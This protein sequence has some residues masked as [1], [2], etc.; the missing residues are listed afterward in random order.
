MQFYCAEINPNSTHSWPGISCMKVMLAGCDFRCGYCNTPE[1]VD[2]KEEYLKLTKDIKREIRQNA[3][4]IQGV[5]FTGG[6][7]GLQRQALL[8]LAREAKRL[9]L[10]VGLQTNG[11][12]PHTISSLLR[13]GL[14]D[15]VAL[16]IKTPFDTELFEKVT[17]SMTFF[18]AT[19]EIISNIKQTIDL[20]SKTEIDIVV[21]TTMIPQLGYDDMSQIAKHV[22]KLGARWV[23]TRFDPQNTLDK[24]TNKSDIPSGRFIIIMRDRLLKEYPDLHFDLDI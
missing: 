20:L 7:P 12:K 16:D 1:L 19:D 4:Y 14:L 11:S 9:E 15:Y 23:L 3:P 6:E 8:S 21:K 22:K 17:R 18:R 13:E 24:D 5:M 2:F 10:K